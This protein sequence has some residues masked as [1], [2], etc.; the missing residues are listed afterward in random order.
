[1][2]ALTTAGYT[3]VKAVSSH[4]QEKKG[5]QGQQQQQQQQQQPYLVLLNKSNG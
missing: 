5:Q 1:L 4:N 3:C 2:A